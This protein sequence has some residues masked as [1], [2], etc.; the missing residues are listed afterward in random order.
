MT[1]LILVL[2][3]IKSIFPSNRSYSKNFKKLVDNRFEINS[4]TD[5]EV[6]SIWKAYDIS[7]KAHSQQ[8]RRSG[9]PYF[10][11]CIEVASNLVKWDMSSDVIIAGLLH[12]SIEDTELTRENVINEFG[13]DIFN[14]V[15]GV[16]KLSD[17]KF[18]SREQKQA[19]NFMKMFLSVASDI[20]VIIIKFSDRLHN[21]QTINYLPLIKQR[22]IAVE[23]R[24]VYA[25]LAHRLGMWNLKAEL[26]DLVLKTLEPKIF[27]KISRKLSTTN[28]QMQ[29]YI[30]E[31]SFP[32]DLELKKNNISYL[33][34]GRSKHK[35]SIYNKMNKKNLSFSEIFD[36][37]AI[38]IIVPKLEECYA[39]L[40]IIHQIYTPIHERFKDFIATPK[41]NGYQSIHTTVFGKN[42]RMFE[43]QIRTREMDKTA[44]EGVAAHFAYK[45]NININDRDSINKHVSWLRD[46]VSSLQNEENNPKEFLDL[47]KI[48]LYEDEIFVFSPKGDLF[49]LKAE[50]TPIDFAFHVHSQV[51]FNCITAKVNGK[52][53]PLNSSLKS[54]DHVEILTSNNQTPSMS[55]LKYVKTA[56]AKNHIKRWIKRQQEIE[57][58]QLGREILDKALKKIK[59]TKLITKISEN[60]KDLGFSNIKLIY[61]ALSS[62]KITVSEIISKYLD[63]DLDLENLDD[64]SLTSKFIRKAR[65]IAKGVV[66]DGIENTMISFGKCCNPIPGDSIVGYIT[67]GRGVTVHRGNCTNIPS[68]SNL[69]RMLNVEW[70]VGNKESFMV[71]LKILG[72]DRKHFLK[73]ITESIS[74]LNINLVSVD[75]KAKEGLATGIF[76]LQ[77]RDTRQLNR[78][79]NKIKII[80]GIIDTQRM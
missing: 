60:P 77:I 66:I 35:N 73:D 13:N 9:E 57:S 18:N 55:W 14:L 33:I 4:L 72:Q 53:V 3:N 5:Y 63:S 27:N 34:K 58:V 67:R 37:L 52:I 2:R 80:N 48:D 39:T 24:D 17:I 11:H 23:T 51:G 56:K 61:T 78:I 20:R 15:D 42:G 46:L 30:D 38:R 19:E 50:S 12:D 25:P 64:E 16:T 32:I 22:R 6:Q 28:K 40:G 75:I 49:Q 21:M 47:L 54:G 71:R 26:E 68:S 29:K 7:K 69:D 45:E 43:V 59:K 36:L 76:I 79:Q 62:G 70:N 65:R 41:I 44:E 74:G 1:N 8:R 31:F 10:N